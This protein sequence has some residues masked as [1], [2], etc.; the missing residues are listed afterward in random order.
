MSKINW[1]LVWAVVVMGALLI[2]LYNVNFAIARDL[3]QWGNVDP[4]VSAWYR[5]LKQPDNPSISC[6][7]EADSYYCDEHA[8][9]DQVYCIVND[10]RD[11]ETLRRT[12]VPNGTEIDIPDTKI[13]R[14]PNLEGRAIVFLSSGG[15]VYCFIGA[16]GV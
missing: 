8:R 5:N 16:G 15:R 14:D 12:P 4:Q 7:G 2:F 6:C 13:N 11:N 1:P 9:G 3:G 10:D